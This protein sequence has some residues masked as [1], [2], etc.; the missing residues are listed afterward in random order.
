MSLGE[1]LPA[2]IARPSAADDDGAWL[3]LLVG[4]RLAATAI[5]AALIAWGGWPRPDALLLL[6]GPISTL[7]L[8]AMPSVRRSPW[9][10]AA[11]SLLTLTFVVLSDDWR[12]P[13]Y[14]L[15]LASLPLPA[16][17][18]PPRRAVWLGV[19]A[20][21]VYFLVALAGGPVPGRLQLVSTETL[22]IHVSLPFIL[23]VAL[24]YAAEALRRLSV[25]RSARE[26][27]A[28]EA[29]R[30]RI[31]W[32]LH[33]SAKQR[34]HAAHLLVTSL[35]GRVPDALDPPSRARPSSSSRPR[36]TWTRASPSCV[37]R[38]RAGVWTPRC[39]P[40]PRSSPRTGGRA[41]M[42]AARRRTCRRWSARTRT[43]SRPR[44]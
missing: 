22:A 19:G 43:G 16:T 36:R 30:K 6:Y 17:S 23:V 12:S 10:W 1:L 20:S 32:E 15:W 5:A 25:E 21:V 11:D 29:E 44:R 13:F 24:A 28:I 42:S 38:S 35:Q 26:R 27:L 4:G 31:A 8:A 39:A 33:D 9:A 37:R 41:S 2:R 18:L 40:A 14:L 34:L 3:L 7:V